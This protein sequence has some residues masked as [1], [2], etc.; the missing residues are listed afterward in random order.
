MMPF[1]V[2]ILIF[3]VVFCHTQLTYCICRTWH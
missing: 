2:V 3:N 1:S